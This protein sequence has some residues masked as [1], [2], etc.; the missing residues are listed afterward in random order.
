MHPRP[1]ETNNRNCLSC[2][3]QFATPTPTDNVVGFAFLVKM[4]KLYRSPVS[5]ILK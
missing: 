3:I 1:L 2:Y 4:F 5:G